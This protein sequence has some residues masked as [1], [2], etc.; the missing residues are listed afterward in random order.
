MN[1]QITVEYG[2]KLATFCEQIDLLLRA[3][4]AG[5]KPAGLFAPADGVNEGYKPS[6]AP[7]AGYMPATGKSPNQVEVFC[8][9]KRVIPRVM[10]GNDF[11]G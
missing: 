2:R 7:S 9:F 4:P 6:P 11:P 1:L 5:D 8:F 3:S 10:A